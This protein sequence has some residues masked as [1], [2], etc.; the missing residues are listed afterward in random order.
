MEFVGIIGRPHFDE[1]KYNK[2]NHEVIEV[3]RNYNCIPMGI[4]ID[5]DNDPILEFN[6]IKKQLDMC[7]RFILQGGSDFYEIDKLIVSY[8]YNLN[9]PVLGI[10][11]GMQTMGATFGGDLIYVGDDHNK[12]DM[13]VHD[14]EIKKNSLLYQIIKKETILVNSRHSFYLDNTDLMVC[15]LKGIIEAV[16]DKNKR[17]F[18]GVQWHPES[19][20]DENSKHLFDFFFKS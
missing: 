19:L 15:A 1:R 9:V 20:D 8:L 10:C 11:L 6:K 12:L 16:E 17:F 5:I 18:L 14:V 3:I 7:S 13:Y 2:Y 4:F